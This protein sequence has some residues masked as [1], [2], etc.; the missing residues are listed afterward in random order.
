MARC[1][2]TVNFAAVGVGLFSLASLIIFP[3][4]L[5]RVP[6]SLI[7]VLAGGCAVA[8]LDL[9]VNTIGDLYTISSAPPAFRLPVLSTLNRWSGAVLG[10]LRG[11]LLLFIACWLLKGSFLPQDAIQN[12]Y[13]L[14]FFCTASPMTLLS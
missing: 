5:P 13:L 3:K 7:A 14:N 9:P 8:V 6:A 1:I 12:S 4:L 10:L 11:G 2:G